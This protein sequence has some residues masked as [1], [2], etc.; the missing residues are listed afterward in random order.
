M[1]YDG[2]INR[3][4]RILEPNDECL[5]KLAYEDDK[6]SYFKRKDI[7]NYVNENYLENDNIVEENLLYDLNTFKTLRDDV[8]IT[9][10]N[11]DVFQGFITIYVAL[12]TDLLKSQRTYIT[13]LCY[14]LLILTIS[15]VIY[16]VRTRKYSN[17]YR[18]KYINNAIYTL[19]TI[20]E[21]MDKYESSRENYKTTKNKY[22]PRAMHQRKRH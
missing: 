14:I 5:Y 3:K 21:D 2:K 13:R 18:L 11:W 7:L 8:E 16:L 1:G 20:K 17:Y 15:S 4:L 9:E 22:S 6:K 19:E 10:K 12:I